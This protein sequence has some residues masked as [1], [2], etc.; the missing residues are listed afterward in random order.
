MEHKLIRL[1][2]K[3]PQDRTV[4][5]SKNHRTMAELVTVSALAFAMI[6]L[7][8]YLALEGQFDQLSTVENITNL[9][10]VPLIIS[11]WTIV[12]IFNVCMAM[13]LAL[14]QKFIERL[15]KVPE[16]EVDRWIFDNLTLF[17]LFAPKMN[18]FC[19][20]MMSSL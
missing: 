6:F 17:N 15:E 3:S 14:P 5:F 16:K 9:L 19:L 10:I 11:Y 12:F 20:L 1:I 18:L 7:G 13:F 2:L 8:N 4:S